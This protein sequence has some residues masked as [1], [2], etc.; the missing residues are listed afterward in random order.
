MRNPR[1][2][3]AAALV[4]MLVGCGEDEKKG[5]DPFAKVDPQITK[6]KDRAAPRWEPLAVMRGT[7]PEERAINVSKRAIQWRARWRCKAGRLSMSVSPEPRSAPEKPGGACPGKGEA[8]WI[9]SGRQRLKVN[10]TGRWSVVVEQQ[11][12]TPLD[13]QPLRGMR[14]KRAKVLARGSFYPMERRGKGRAALYR[15]PGGRLA[16]RFENFSTSSNTDLFVWLSEATRPR[17]TKQAVAAPYKEIGLLKSTLGSQ[18]YVLP[19]SV[20]ASDLKSIVIWCEPVRIAYT[21]ARLKR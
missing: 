10:A 9:Q 3:V 20:D 15:L 17:T 12:D 4:A 2:L 11:V 5:G 18:N 7:S 14:S 6:V 8:E 19:R 16:L 1:A 21:A 13:E